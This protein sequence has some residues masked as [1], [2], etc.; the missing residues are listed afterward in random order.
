MKI[1][2]IP[3]WLRYEYKT[4]CPTCNYEQKV[5]TQKDN[6]PEYATEVYVK[7]HC[8]KLLEFVLTVN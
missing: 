2:K 6:M 8:G 7:C 4:I 3:K 1:D 5:L